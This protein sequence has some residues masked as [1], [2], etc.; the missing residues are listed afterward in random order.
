M[1][2]NCPRGHVRSKCMQFI[3]WFISK[4]IYVYNYGPLQQEVEKIFTIFMHVHLAFLKSV[5]RNAKI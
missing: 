5:F 3:Y 4:D 2:K 1:F